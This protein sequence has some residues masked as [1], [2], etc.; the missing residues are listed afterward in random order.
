MLITLQVQTHLR[1]VVLS[2]FSFDFLNSEGEF[3]L[4][5]GDD[6]ILLL[7]NDG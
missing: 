5:C 1:E 7:S 4:D 3:L 2:S 6:N